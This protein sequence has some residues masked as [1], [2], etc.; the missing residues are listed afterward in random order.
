[1][2]HEC[3]MVFTISFILIKL[4]LDWNKNKKINKDN[5]YY[6]FGFLGSLVLLLSPANQNRLISDEIWSSLSIFEKLIK[7]IPIISRNLFDLMNIKNIL[8]YFYISYIIGLL[9]KDKKVHV[10]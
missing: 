3:T 1:M 7:S 2:I 5:I 10:I 4:F 9:I 6:L 8:V